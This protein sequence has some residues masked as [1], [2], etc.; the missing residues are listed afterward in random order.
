MNTI[1]ICSVAGKT[2]DLAFHCMP[3]VCGPIDIIGYG[4]GLNVSVNVLMRCLGSYIAM[5][6]SSGKCNLDVGIH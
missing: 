4:G 2:C 6:F 1:I 3:R 5:N